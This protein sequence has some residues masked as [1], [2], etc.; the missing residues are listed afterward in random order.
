MH[1]WWVVC[2]TCCCS[3]G[4]NHEP[5]LHS[6]GA[7]VNRPTILASLLDSGSDTGAT[8][9]RSQLP[10]MHLRL[11]KKKK[12]GSAAGQRE[13]PMPSQII[14]AGAIFNVAATRSPF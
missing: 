10:N 7:T 6:L 14:G 8:L 4:S 12:K 13:K 1:V 5:P 9:A 2:L 3:V 11:K